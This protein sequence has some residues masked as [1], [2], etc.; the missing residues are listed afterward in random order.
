MTS[1][2]GISFELL[3]MQVKAIVTEELILIV[4]VEGLVNSLVF[5]T[6]II[7]KTQR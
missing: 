1:V 6:G 7:S 2:K 4:N 5:V 3:Q